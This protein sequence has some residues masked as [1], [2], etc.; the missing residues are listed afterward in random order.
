M[1]HRPR[2]DDIDSAKGLA[3]VLVVLGHLVG[4]DGGSLPKDF[5]WYVLINRAIYEFH[6]PFFMFLS[7]YIFLYTYTPIRTVRDY[8]HYAVRK[9]WRF[10]P[11]FLLFGGLMIAGKVIGQ[12]YLRVNSPPESFWQ[13]FEGI[14]IRPM[15]SHAAS[16]WYVYAL[17]VFQFLLPVALWL[18]RG[19]LEP[20]LVIGLA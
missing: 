17:L 6:M 7:G 15:A 16:L 12:H 11:P 1:T 14:L 2:L 20:L 13:G 9:F 18:S 10:G 4:G 8:G 5:Y 19:R 3:I